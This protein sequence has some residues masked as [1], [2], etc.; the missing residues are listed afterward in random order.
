[1]DMVNIKINGVAVSVPQ[2]STI[3]EAARYAGIE[4]PTLCYLKKINAIGACRICVVEV[5][6][7]RSL[8]AACVYPV[9]EG[10]EVFTNT[11]AVRNSRK[12]TLELI[13]SNHDKKCLS[14]V[15]SGNCELQKLCNDYGVDENK[16][17]GAMTPSEIDDSAAHL[18]RNNKKC[19]LCR[20]CVAACREQFVNVIGAN[21]RGFDTNI[22]CA[23]EKKLADVPCISCGQCIVA[24]PTGALTEKD[25]IDEVF[26]AIADPKKHVVVH[27]APSVRVTLGE[28]FGM[29]I[30]SN[31]EGKMAAALRRLGFDKVFDTDFGA[32]LTIME[33]ANEFVERVKNGGVLPMITSCSPGWVKFCETYYP[34]SPASLRSRWKALPSRPTMPRRTALIRRTSSAF[35]SCPVPRRSSRSAVTTRARQ[36]FRMSISHSLPVS[37]PE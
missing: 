20:R 36:A 15:R 25:Q 10:M 30:G 27:T 8:V 4:I 13:L 21:A 6:G 1:M 12:T 23:F 2:G 19:I 24:C 17:E 35:P 29:P 22:G 16:F 31:V 37:L 32:D 33:E 26:A 9:N 34:D 5:K 18:V 7:A 14:C 28:C 3:L 11:P